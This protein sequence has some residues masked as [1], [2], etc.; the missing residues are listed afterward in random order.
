MQDL[1]EWKK[2]VGV[3]DFDIWPSDKI[4]D[5]LAGAPEIRASFAAWVT[6]SDVLASILDKTN[7]GSVDFAPSIR[8]ALGYGIRRDQFVRLKDAGSVNDP[9]IRT[10]QVFV[11]LPLKNKNNTGDAP[12]RNVLS[13]LI[14]RSKDKFGFELDIGNTPNDL[15]SARNK[16]VLL[17]G[18]GQGKSTL[19]SFGAQLFRAHL[20][21]DD[22]ASQRDI[23]TATV[24]QEI[25]IRAANEKIDHDIPRRYPVF[26]SLPR[27]AD[28]ITA[29]RNAGRMFPSIL[30]QI[31]RD[32]S[33]A[34]DTPIQRE[35]L[36]KWLKHYP[37]IIFL[38]GLD[39]VPPS[40]ERIPIL[41][42]I[43][44]FDS[45]ISTTSADVL[46]VVTTRPQGYSHDLASE[47]WEHWYLDDLSTER[48][49]AY[50]EALGSARYPD[51]LER[52]VE[53]L[54]SLREASLRPAT[55]RL[56]SNPLQVTI[57]QLIVD[58]GGS[59]P[60]ARWSLFH[61]YFE[62]LK[63]REKAK[64]GQTQRAI[65][66]NWTLLGP[67]H[68][69]A[70]LILHIDSEV[71]GGAEAF[72]DRERFEQLAKAYLLSLGH[73][74]REVSARVSEL[75]D[76][77]LQRLVLLSARE[78][79]R[80][81]F[82]VRSMQ[83]FMAAAA[84]T[85]G[86]AQIVSER[87][88]YIAGIAHWTHVF[89]IAASRC[90]SEDAFHH[91]RTAVCAIPR[92]L[93]TNSVDLI[94]RNGARL[95]LDLFVDGLGTD[96][97]ISRRLLAL[98]ALELLHLGPEDFET[99]LPNLWEECTEE[100]L[101]ECVL[102][103]SSEVG[104]PVALASWRLALNLLAKDIRRY[105]DFVL[106]N[107]PQDG[108]DLC[109]IVNGNDVPLPNPE[110]VAAIAS[111]LVA[112]AA[113]AI[114]RSGH[115]FWDAIRRPPPEGWPVSH[116]ALQRLNP[117]HLE[118]GELRSPLKILTPMTTT[119]VIFVSTDTN[120]FSQLCEIKGAAAAW[121][122]VISAGKF[123][124]N[125]TTESLAEALQ[126]ISAQQAI[127]EEARRLI[128]IMP[129][130]LA[131]LVE[132]SETPKELLELAARAA[133]GEFGDRDDWRA[134]EG[135]WAADGVDE[136]DIEHAAE[137]GTFL[138]PEIASI[139]S[140]YIYRYSVSYKGEETVESILKM[141]EFTKK[142]KSGRVRERFSNLICFSMIAINPKSIESKETAYKI[143]EFLTE[144]TGKIHPPILGIFDDYLWNYDDIVDSLSLIAE[145]CEGG[146][147]DRLQVDADLL[148]SAY[149]AKA[150]ARRGLLYALSLSLAA[151]GKNMESISKID[152]T[153]LKRRATDSLPVLFSCAL[154]SALRGEMAPD[155]FA[156]NYHSHG[157]RYVG[158]RPV[159]LLFGRAPITEEFRQRFLIELIR[160][161]VGISNRERASLREVLSSILNKRQSRLSQTSVWK[162]L[163]LPTDALSLFPQDHLADHPLSPTI[164]APH[165]TPL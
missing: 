137:L 8:R 108:R 53:L 100:V 38:D 107:I 103:N 5:L 30:Q 114:F 112:S 110:I 14:S 71:G 104:S 50:A 39:E 96:H 136:R 1:Q 65:E 102:Q 150:N 124:E 160:S 91:L 57:M 77:A 101:F 9:Q 113:S 69:R 139:G 106:R 15:V 163:G 143:I 10:G 138:H 41:D 117:L 145:K 58:T 126:E 40:G 4:E 36:R 75:V 146:W 27:Y 161:P 78:E 13:E 22:K 76:V 21:S 64:G 33:V 35:D 88:K 158:M 56:M 26:L 131:A 119:E 51:D 18:P 63:R 132:Q 70:G 128:S 52:R 59:V 83:E 129:W 157:R 130:P 28:A 162:S 155:E 19:S 74:A 68:Q 121:T 153:S 159:A 154:L 29:A 24:A 92:A 48:A 82:D 37:W 86:D 147:E 116:S 165:T 99:R 73:E 43:K 16:I 55:S 95:S 54:R 151:G 6:P 123:A 72:L 135:R 105:S 62:V 118:T 140:P 61:E 81:S 120:V 115:S 109:N 3:R 149:N 31:A 2:S 111:R 152:P 42:A 144:H 7:F 12:Q 142:L 25:L 49:L 20:F 32:L 98:H 141:I 85:S 45:E 133:N 47:L 94:V 87:L 90:F 17:G 66:R 80:I 93:E 97:P 34:A 89:M 127:F 125:P 79:G 84:L 46:I 134:A 60:P 122:P 67:I 11:D 164:A 148:V 44:D 156:I 23:A